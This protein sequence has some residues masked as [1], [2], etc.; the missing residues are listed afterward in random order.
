M[1][2]NISR[3]ALDGE[4]LTVNWNLTIAM[5][6]ISATVEYGQ[7][8]KIQAVDGVA[9][10]YLDRLYEL[11]DDTAGDETAQPM[12]AASNGMMGSYA[13]WETGYSG[14]GQRIAIID[15]GI[16]TDHDSFRA[17]AF[18]YSL[19]ATAAEAGKT[20][21]DYDLLDAEEIARV[22]PQLNAYARNP[23]ITGESVHVSE[24]I[25]YGFNYRQ[26][27][28]AVDNDSISGDH[29]THVAGIASAN[30]Y[31]PAGDGTFTTQANG[32]VGSAPDAQLLAMKVFSNGTGAYETDYMAAIEDAILLGAD[33]INLSLGS[34][35]GGF[36]NSGDEYFDKIF[37][38]LGVTAGV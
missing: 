36:T 22:L 31:V 1:V 6:A 32:V 13:A 9:A 37:E 15:T 17:D 27:N 7:I 14:A 8:E 26:N 12:T 25:A 35:I 4:A 29:G 3:Q 20:V 19:E 11:I 21:D 5:N 33:A 18:L 34:S 16:D 38:N 10:V 23:E 28:E 30:R 24:K 2:Q